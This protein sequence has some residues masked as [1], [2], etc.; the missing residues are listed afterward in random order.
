[1]R[2]EIIN[3]NDFIAYITKEYISYDNDLEE[4]IKIV[5]CKLNDLYD[6]NTDSGYFN[7]NLYKNNNYGTVLEIKK[8]SDD[9]YSYN[10]NLEIEEYDT[11]FY[12]ETNEIEKNNIYFNNKIYKKIVDK[13]DDNTN[14]LYKNLEKTKIID[15]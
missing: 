10:L 7:I 12:A 4:Y 6:L 11:D 15:I 13:I 5:F 3:D 8:I 9:Y 2:V 1:M 14:I